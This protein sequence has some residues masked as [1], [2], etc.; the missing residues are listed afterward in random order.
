MAMGDITPLQDII[1]QNRYVSYQ[2]GDYAGP[3]VGIPLGLG[4]KLLTKRTFNWPR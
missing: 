3:G 2:T 1:L 4:E